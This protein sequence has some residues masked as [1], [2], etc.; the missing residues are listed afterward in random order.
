M[1]DAHVCPARTLPEL[2]HAPRPPGGDPRTGR[3][4]WRCPE[5]GAYVVESH[6]LVAEAL[7]RP[8]D[9]SNRYSLSL[10]D[11][12]YPAAEVE[13]IYREG[14]CLWART[15][16]A[17]D[18]P[19]H[20]R[21][22][23]LVERVFS[24]AKVAAIEPYIRETGARLLADWPAGDTVD[25]MAAYAV[26]LPTTVIARELGVAAGD[27]ARFK[28]WSDAAVA[29]LSLNA[30]REAHLHAARAGVEFQRYFAP[31]LADATRRPAGSLIDLVANAAREAGAG[32]TLAEQ[33]SLLHTLMIAGHETTTATLG[34]LCLRLAQAPQAWGSLRAAESERRRWVEEVL[35]LAAP[36]QGLFRVARR[37][38]TLGGV[39]IPA[40]ALL[41]LRFAAANRD[42]AAFVDADAI[43][44]DRP[45]VPAHYTFGGGLHFCIGAGLARRE[46]AV[47]LEQLLARFERLDLAVEPAALRWS[48][49]V[50]TRGLLALPLR[51]SPRANLSLESANEP[52]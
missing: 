34:E 26:P 25:A 20:R 9:F 23:A 42:P 1:S 36:A 33:L 30:T 27:A 15:L 16:S 2:A 12:G 44:L 43:R 19:E 7:A 22:R 29:T 17:N 10:L 40:R 38:T 14:G 18:P 48:A 47:A 28:A 45:S 49:S 51:A 37:D 24:P 6:A 4:L 35:R 3:A 52:A 32:F 8:E 13:A 5:T 11:P 31:L 21:F 50:T 41:S 46:L 39:A